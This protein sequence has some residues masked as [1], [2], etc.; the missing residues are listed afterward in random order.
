MLLLSNSFFKRHYPNFI[1]IALTQFR[2]ADIAA[3]SKKVMG[4]AKE[5]LVHMSGRFML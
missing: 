5:R 4:K 3:N 1:N 2:C